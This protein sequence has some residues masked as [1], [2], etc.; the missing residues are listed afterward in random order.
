MK[1]FKKIAII[2]LC[3]LLPMKAGSQGSPVIDVSAI[4]ATI[5]GF[6]E[7]VG[8]ATKSG[9][10]LANQLDVTKKTY[11]KMKELKEFYDKIDAYVYNM[12]EVMDIIETSTAITKS[13][14]DIYKNAATSRVYEPRE[15]AFLLDQL[16]IYVKEVASLTQRVSKILDPKIFKWS[17]ADRV[18]GIDESKTAMTRIK[19]ALGILSDKVEDQTETRKEV[20]ELIEKGAVSPLEA[21]YLTLDNLTGGLPAGLDLTYLLMKA[22]ENA[23]KI[24]ATTEETSSSR[25]KGVAGQVAP[26]FWALT[27]FVFL[28]GLFK[29]VRK[30]QA[31]EDVGKAISIWIT[32]VLLLL[33]FGQIYTTIFS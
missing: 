27:A 6:V 12:Q 25:M 9:V 17:S 13:A 33:I 5:A 11:D 8:V 15:L 14:S 22:G 16:T 23:K 18:K 26:L 19:E 4:I 28:F 1:K 3:G 7:S 31:Q 21:A 30:A 29:V 2:L 10:E 24:E 20:K 32:A